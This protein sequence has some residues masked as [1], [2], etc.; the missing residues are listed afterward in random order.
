MTNEEMELVVSK[1]M[2]AI[3]CSEKENMDKNRSR[4]DDKQNARGKK[5]N[6]VS[7]ERLARELMEIMREH[8]SEDEAHRRI[9]AKLSQI[10]AK[11]NAKKNYHEGYDLDD[12]YEETYYNKHG[13]K[14]NESKST[15]KEVEHDRDER[16]EYHRRKDKKENEVSYVDR[17]HH[18][19]IIA[20]LRDN[21][22]F[23]DS[24]IDEIYGEFYDDPFWRRE[25]RKENS[26]EPRK[27]Y[28]DKLRNARDTYN[29][30]EAVIETKYSQLE[31]GKSRYGSGD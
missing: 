6:E 31:R 22:N 13:K 1:V 27:N 24:D 15:H 29:K 12:D 23:T 25:N 20:K 9:L 10:E 2:N 26:A 18:E 19:A 11:E 14:S 3:K 17:S 8:K 7:H 28:F 4:D 16:E 21:H 5:E 30:P